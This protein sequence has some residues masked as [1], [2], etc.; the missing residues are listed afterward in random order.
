[1]VIIVLRPHFQG[2][3]RSVPVLPHD[4]ELEVELVEAES[5]DGASILEDAGAA[6]LYV[7]G[8]RG[9]GDGLRSSSN[10]AQDCKP[11]FR[12]AQGHRGI[13]SRSLELDMPVLGMGVGLFLL[14]E[15]FGGKTPETTGSILTKPGTEAK[16]QTRRT[17]YVS[18]GSKTAAI[19][20]AGGFFRLNGTAPLPSL[21]DSH[22]A[23]RLL[24]SAYAVENGAVEG[25]ES[26]EHDWVL[27][28]RADLG[29]EDK[30]PRGF[31]GIFQAFVERCQEFQLA[32]AVP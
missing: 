31:S 26:A 25:L 21:L 13:L 4:A 1:M 30:L 22:R 6:G 32:R 2:E 9:T 12:W 19:L 14:N 17:I 15:V 10:G 29:S 3:F 23:P 28:F 18:P 27:G 7:L 8:N 5:Y 24:A 16:K 11:S 20:G